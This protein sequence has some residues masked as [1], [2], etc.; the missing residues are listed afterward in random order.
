[1]MENPNDMQ[2][3]SGRENLWNELKNIIHNAVNNNPD[4][5]AS[6][7]KYLNEIASGE[8]EFIKIPDNLNSMISTFL[9]AKSLEDVGAAWEKLSDEENENMK[10]KYSD[11]IS[12]GMKRSNDYLANYNTPD[13]KQFNLDLAESG[14]FARIFQNDFV[15]T[16][17]QTIFPSKDIPD[18]V[19][20]SDKIYMSLRNSV[21]NNPVYEWGFI[22]PE[23]QKNYMNLHGLSRPAQ[24]GISIA[25]KNGVSLN[26]I[27]HAVDYIQSTFNK[28]DQESMI[29]A[30]TSREAIKL[31]K[32]Y[33]DIHIGDLI[34][35]TLEETEANLWRLIK[36]KDGINQSI[37]AN[38]KPGS[39][40][41]I[42]DEKPSNKPK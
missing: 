3:M 12:V 7:I 36:V 15:T 39:Q 26:E 20:L 2:V 11:H 19:K 6:E 38:A 4:L 35:A 22:E 33:P 8:L 24:L 42:E 32:A 13:E 30:L 27:N 10:Q 5:D 23:N 21:I 34:K 25:L 31:Y 1:M 28:Q 40:N 16:Y 9:Q 41:K 14:G 17:F 37:F 29:H 18:Y